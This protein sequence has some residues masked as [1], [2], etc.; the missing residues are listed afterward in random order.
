[1]ATDSMITASTPMKAAPANRPMPSPPA[2]TLIFISDFA[3]ATSCRNRVDMSRLASAKRRPRVG[4][5]L[6]GTSECGRV[7]GALL[8]WV[9]VP[10]SCPERTGTK[11]ADRARS[12]F[13]AV[14][15]LRAVRPAPAAQHHRRQQA[16]HYGPGE[17]RG[18]RGL[19]LRR[20]EGQV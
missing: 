8:A 13:R 18:L 16:G 1:M 19:C 7:T 15:L 9:M 5:S 6:L 14:A 11:P 17:D 3:S 2:L 10:P 20:P 12:A 4:S